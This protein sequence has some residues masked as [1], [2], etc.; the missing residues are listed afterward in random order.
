ML[1][2]YAHIGGFYRMLLPKASI[3]GF[4]A[5]K[6]LKPGRLALATGHSRD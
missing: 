2:A 1:S 6:E 4:A 5:K 3:E